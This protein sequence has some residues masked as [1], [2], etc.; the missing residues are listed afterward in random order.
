MCKDTVIYCKVN[1]VA[2]HQCQV[3]IHDR[4]YLNTFNYLKAL[5]TIRKILKA[6][7]RAIN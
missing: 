7:I 1:V 4:V 6:R 5:S 2:E 3:I